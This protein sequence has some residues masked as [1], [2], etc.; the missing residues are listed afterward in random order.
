[1][2]VQWGG[3]GEQ[4]APASAWVAHLARRTSETPIC[5]GRGV[6]WEKDGV[7]FEGGPETASELPAKRLGASWE[8]LF[9]EKDGR[10]HTE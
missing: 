4:V 5:L 10:P 2:C 6:F 3:R 8:L 7:L 1:M 9:S